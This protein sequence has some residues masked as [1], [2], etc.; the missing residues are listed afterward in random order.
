MPRTTFYA[1]EKV[2]VTFQPNIGLDAAARHSVV[3]ILNIILAD[4][5]VLLFK[6]HRAEEHPGETVGPDLKS[7]F[8]AQCIQIDQILLEVA[9]RINILGGSPIHNHEEFIDTARLYESPYALP[10]STAIL[11]DQEALIRYLREDAQKCSEVYEDQGSFF[12]IVSLIR[13]HEKMAWTLRPYIEPG[14][15]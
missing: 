1:N 10:G 7:L 2:Q 13:Q 3:E 15:A 4:E 9:E 14:L 8:K 6:T 11:A 5:S 12:Q